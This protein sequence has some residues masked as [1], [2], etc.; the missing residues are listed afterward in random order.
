LHAS[1]HRSA[2]P[3]VHAALHGTLGIKGD[4]GIADDALGRATK[5]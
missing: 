1:A 4:T 3:I 2:A 5:T